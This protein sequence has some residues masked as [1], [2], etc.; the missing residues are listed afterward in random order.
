MGK[1]WEWFLKSLTPQQVC[2]LC[3]LCT[4]GAGLYGVNTFA[5]DSEVKQIRVELLQQRLLDLRIRQCDAV[6]LLQPASFFAG[7]I[8][9]QSDKYEALTG[10]KPELPT[11]QEL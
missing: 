3:L 7:Q 11:C 10:R 4:F 2:W 1:V 5:K 6:R 9:D 8:T